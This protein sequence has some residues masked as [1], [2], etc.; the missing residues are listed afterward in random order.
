M[1]AAPDFVTS[2]TARRF[3][4][5]LGLLP[6][7][8]HWMLTRPTLWPYLALPIAL[9]TALILGA[10]AATWAWGTDVTTT[11]LPPPSTE[12]WMGALALTL[13]KVSNGVVHLAL[14]LGLSI[15]S[16]FLGNALA[17]PFYELLSARVEGLVRGVE[18]DEPFTL[19]QALRDVAQSLAHT[20]ACLA[21]WA[22]LA[23]PITA[24]NLVPL[25]GQA[26]AFVAGLGVSGFFVAREALDH[27]MARR[28]MTLR[29]K[30]GLCWDHLATVEGL[31]VGI[32]A[33]LAIPFANFLSMPAAAIAGTLL[34]L[35]LQDAGLIPEDRPPGWRSTPE[36]A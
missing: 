7:S 9:T 22:A 33:L 12:G 20:T 31:G 30:L 11:F 8:L 17:A 19:A 27:P 6:R 28:R 35:D 1:S 21:L 23:C 36:S 13:W 29:R 26:V 24:L 32:T 16:W 2:P 15:L 14:F 5:G 34:Y 18:L 25:A 4:Y 10:L 3:T